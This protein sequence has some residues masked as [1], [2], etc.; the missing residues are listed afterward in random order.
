MNTSSTQDGTRDLT[1]R[2]K[3]L[4]LSAA[5]FTGILVVVVVSMVLLNEARIGGH[6]YK[7]IQENKDALE[8][9]ALLKS[10]LFQINNEMQKVTLGDRYGCDK[11]NRRHHPEPDK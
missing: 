3:M 11:E 6:S 7:V 2:T 8:S 4:L 5:A 10:D 9:I 1:L